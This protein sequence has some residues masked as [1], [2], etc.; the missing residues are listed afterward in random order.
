MR[1]SSVKQSSRKIGRF[2]AS[3]RKKKGYEFLEDALMLVVGASP[4][5]PLPSKRRAAF[6]DLLALANRA[7]ESG[8]WPVRHTYV[9]GRCCVHLDECRSWAEGV[10]P[11]LGRADL[12]D[13]VLRLERHALDVLCLRD[14]QVDGGKEVKPD[15]KDCVS[16]FRSGNDADIRQ[17]LFYATQIES[18]PKTNAEEKSA[19]QA[20]Q[21]LPELW[22]EIESKHPNLR[23]LAS[24][25]SFHRRLV[26]DPLTKERL[27]EE[28]RQE[29]EETRPHVERGRKS[30]KD[31]TKGADVTNKKYEE[32]RKDAKAYAKQEWADG[33][34][35]R[36]GEMA[37]DIIDTLFVGDVEVSTIKNWISDSAP[38]HLKGKPG[39]PKK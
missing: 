5:Y 10:K 14:L 17:L 29:L 27:L 30:K 18:F 1:R 8:D 3:H 25:L 21:E 22:N 39:R 38:E 15:P 2:F 35:L 36:P 19:A 37:Q 6:L 34:S 26:P 32:A 7:R 33:S 12:K 28:P 4:A 31:H 20:L 9:S 13:E 24:R 23:L 16:I 11:D